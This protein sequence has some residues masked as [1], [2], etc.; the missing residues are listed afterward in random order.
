MDNSW[1]GIELKEKIMCFFNK[2]LRY[3]EFIHLKAN[4]F[5]NSTG[6]GIANDQI[7]HTQ[8]NKHLFEFFEYR[9]EVW[10]PDSLLRGHLRDK[11]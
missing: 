3:I 10:N 11:D 7:P 8:T 5:W 2:N 1:G 6:R 4:F 9:L